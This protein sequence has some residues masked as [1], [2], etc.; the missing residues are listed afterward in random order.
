MIID[1]YAVS[2]ENALLMN[3]YEHQE[4]LMRKTAFSLRVTS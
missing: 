3:E 4:N 1:T 2:T